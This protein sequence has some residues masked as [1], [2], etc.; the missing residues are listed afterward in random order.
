[1]DPALLPMSGHLS[2]FFFTNSPVVYYNGIVGMIE[3]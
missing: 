1:M 2:D 3:N